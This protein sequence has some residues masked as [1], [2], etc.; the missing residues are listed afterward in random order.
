MIQFI[1]HGRPSPAG[2]KRHVGNGI[3]VDSSG[4][5]GKAWRAVVQDAAREVFSGDLLRGPLRVQ[6][7]FYKPRPKCH[8]GS[9][10]KSATLKA[11][12][13]EYPTGRP[14]CLKLARAVEDALTGVLWADDSQI[15]DE[16][17]SKRYGEPA[18]CAVLIHMLSDIATEAQ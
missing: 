1:A 15:V 14:D 7:V 13:P 6:F 10:S 11:T 16:V 2:S 3:V 5:K 4:E 8:F 9:G 18:R 17:L 12:A